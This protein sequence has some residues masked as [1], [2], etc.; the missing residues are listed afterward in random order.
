MSVKEGAEGAG[1]ATQDGVLYCTVHP[2]VETVLRCNNCGRPMCIRCAVL[3]PVGYR[4]KECVSK[5]QEVFFTSGVAD[6][7]IA[8][9]VAF[10][11]SALMGSV[12]LSIGSLLITLFLSAPVGGLISEVVH[13]AIGR[14]RGRYT[15]LVV[16]LATA[17]GAVPIT[18]WRLWPA[19]QA[20]V[21]IPMLALLGP[22]LY[23]VLAA[24]TAAARFRY[25]R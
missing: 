14:R 20:G 15:W 25:G 11:L 9:G 17:A 21:P 10:L 3:T 8:A 19:L 18:L 1:E 4:C 13:R 23:A 7:W 22:L 24:A 6:Y 12:L 5:R 16:A 2:T